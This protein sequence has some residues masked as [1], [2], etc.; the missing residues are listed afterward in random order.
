MVYDANIVYIYICIIL[1]YIILYYI[2]L[3]YII[4]YYI[5]L[6]YIILYI[7]I[8]IYVYVYMYMYMYIFVLHMTSFVFSTCGKWT[9]KIHPPAPLAGPCPWRTK[10]RQMEGEKRAPKDGALL[11]KILVK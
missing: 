7:Y 6:Y 3:Y 11:K 2:I 4:L 8:Y 10:D 1:Y 9:M 5:I